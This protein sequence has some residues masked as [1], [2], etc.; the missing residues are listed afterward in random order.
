[1][2]WLSNLFDGAFG[3]QDGSESEPAQPACSRQQYVPYESESVDN[4]TAVIYRCQTEYIG[5]TYRTPGRN[6]DHLRDDDSCGQVGGISHVAVQYDNPDPRELH[7]REEEEINCW[8]PPGNRIPWA[9]GRW[10]NAWRNGQ[11]E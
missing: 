7:R 9:P 6:G 8:N 1:M 4:G 2:S 5:S 10:P 3:N 11:G